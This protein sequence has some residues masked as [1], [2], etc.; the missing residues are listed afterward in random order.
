MGYNNLRNIVPRKTLHILNAQ[1]ISVNKSV[2]DTRMIEVF[3]FTQVCD[4][5]I[6]LS[7]WLNHVTIR[8]YS[9][10]SLKY[11]TIQFYSVTGSRMLQLDCTQWKAQ[12]CDK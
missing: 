6:L 2:K 5:L 9:Q 4:N 10:K 12:A 8:I 7:D 1:Y 3:D 11:V